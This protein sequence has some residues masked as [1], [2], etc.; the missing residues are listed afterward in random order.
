MVIKCTL[1]TLLSLQ[2]RGIK[3]IRI[4]VQ[5]WPPS[6]RG[7]LS[8]SCTEVV[9]ME[10]HFPVPTPA[11][12]NDYSTFCL[13]IWRFRVPRANGIM[14]YLSFHVWLIS[15]SITF[16]GFTCVT[17]CIRFP[18]LFKGW[19]I[20]HYMYWPHGLHLFIFW[21][22]FVLVQPLDDGEYCCLEIDVQITTH[23]AAFNYYGKYLEVGLLDS[24]LILC[25]IFLRKCYSL[26]HGV[27]TISYFYQQCT[28]VLISQSSCQNSVFLFCLFFKNSHP[29]GCEV[30]SPCGFDLNFS[31]ILN[32]V[33]HPIRS[34]LAVCT[35][36]WSTS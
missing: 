35:A 8:S 11:P 20:F 32:G 36:S 9:P 14:Q 30:V 16:S 22:I 34:L 28:R 21:R 7:N 31:L 5:P 19:V 17:A 33:K 25:L 2:F 27:S 13:W 4:V 18:F 26:F 29:S 23:V 3:Y 10:H 1:H 24:T 15:L 6:I 12:G